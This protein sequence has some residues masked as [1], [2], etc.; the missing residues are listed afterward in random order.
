VADHIGGE[1]VDNQDEVELGAV[2]EAVRA[3]QACQ[4]RAYAAEMGAT[5]LA[6]VQ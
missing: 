6:L 1:F 2:G 5:E 4:R 3:R